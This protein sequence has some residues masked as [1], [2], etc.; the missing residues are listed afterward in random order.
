QG[1]LDS[2]GHRGAL[3]RP[4]TRLLHPP[5]RP[6][7]PDPQTHRPAPSP[8]RQTDHHRRPRRRPTHQLTHTHHTRV[9]R[10]PTM[11]SPATVRPLRTVNLVARPTTTILPDPFLQ[12]RAPSASSLCPS[13]AAR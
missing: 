2:A 3:H 5:H 1:H 11:P 12:E 13:A 7:D 9:G 10:T 8:D 4:R 6:A